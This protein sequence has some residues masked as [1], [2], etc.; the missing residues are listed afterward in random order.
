MKI[1]KPSTQTLQRQ[2]TLLKKKQVI[3]CENLNTNILQNN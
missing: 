2:N 3:P 1:N